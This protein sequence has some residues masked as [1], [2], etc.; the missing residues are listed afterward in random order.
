MLLKI[1]L[2]ANLDRTAKERQI[3]TDNSDSEYD[4]YVNFV[5]SELMNNKEFKNKNLS[6]V[7]QSGIKIYTN[8]DKDVQNITR[9]Y[10]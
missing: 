3:G 6:D 2:K 5:K 4:S 7:L 10:R 9:S 1:N 8:M